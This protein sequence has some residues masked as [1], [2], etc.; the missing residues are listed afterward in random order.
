[1]NTHK[2]SLLKLAYFVLNLTL[3]R[4]VTSTARHSEN[5]TC[6][7][8]MSTAH[9]AALSHSFDYIST[10]GRKC[11]RAALYVFMKVLALL[12]CGRQLLQIIASYFLSSRI[13]GFLFAVPNFTAGFMCLWNEGMKYETNVITIVT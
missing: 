7:G 4:G 3:Q 13:L 12:W 1:M 5:V 11:N 8:V 9:H 10:T 2:L 6:R